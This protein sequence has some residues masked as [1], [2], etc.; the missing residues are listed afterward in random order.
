MRL[1]DPNVWGKLLTTLLSDPDL[2]G[3]LGTAGRERALTFSW[4]QVAARIVGHYVRL[5]PGLA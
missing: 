5:N 2:A 1:R 3:R 4:P